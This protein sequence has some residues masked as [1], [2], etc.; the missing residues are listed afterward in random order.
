MDESSPSH[1]QPTIGRGGEV[2]T[3]N[4]VF[5][6]PEFATQDEN[7]DKFDLAEPLTIK[8]AAK[9][10]KIFQKNLPDDIVDVDTGNG[11]SNLPL[12]DGE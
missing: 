12:G 11:I 6:I 5:S 8:E 9:A 7:D 1:I 3:D 2:R 10:T 4:G